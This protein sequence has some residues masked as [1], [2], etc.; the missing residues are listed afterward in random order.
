MNIDRL[1]EDSQAI[2]I[3]IIGERTNVWRNGQVV[4]RETGP[5]ASTVY[6]LLNHLERVEF[7][8]APRGVGSG[9]DDQ[10]RE[11]LTY[12]ERTFVH[13]G[14]WDES[15][16]FKIGY[17]MRDLHQVSASFTIPVDAQW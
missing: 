3:P 6:A 8:G 17:L 1:P 16:L 15:S 12:I 13:P 10:G 5:W 11:L 14:P 9:V 7:A 4:L 2:E